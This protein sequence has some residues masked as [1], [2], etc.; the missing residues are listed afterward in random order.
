M[1]VGF[2][3]WVA[4]FCDSHWLEWPRSPHEYLL[5]LCVPI[6][7]Q[8]CQAECLCCAHILRSWSRREPTLWTCKPF[9]TILNAIKLTW[10]KERL[11]VI[12]TVWL[13]N[14]GSHWM[15]MWTRGWGS[16]L[17]NIFIYELWFG[18]VMHTDVHPQSLSFRSLFSQTLHTLVK[19][20]NKF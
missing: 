17:H 6:G 1:V 3:W 16:R 14:A 5:S 20:K 10:P 2:G 18:I 13:H 12:G 4:L 15:E 9:W 11:Y 7:G 19:N 8:C